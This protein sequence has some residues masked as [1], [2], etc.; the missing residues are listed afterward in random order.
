MRKSSLCSL[1][2]SASWKA[3]FSEANYRCRT[4]HAFLIQWHNPVH[5]PCFFYTLQNTNL[6]MSTQCSIIVLSCDI[7]IL[8]LYNCRH[9]TIY[10]V[11]KIHSSQL[12]PASRYD[13]ISIEKKRIIYC[14]AS[15]SILLGGRQ[16]LGK[17][18]L[19]ALGCCWS[20]F[21]YY[22]K[23]WNGKNIHIW[24]CENFLSLD[25]KNILLF[26]YPL[27]MFDTLPRKNLLLPPKQRFQF[28]PFGPFSWWIL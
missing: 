4:L 23:A 11:S 6:R 16:N 14:H 12:Y 9:F 15:Q 27:A 18:L 8:L 7:I 26:G 20:H 25:M 5:F 1:Q 28:S 19:F 10:L 3:Y 24:K 22:G 2:C 21:N 13:E 17:R